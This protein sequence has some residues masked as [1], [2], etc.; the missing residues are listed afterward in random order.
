MMAE[1]NCVYYRNCKEGSL[2]SEISDITEVEEF[3]YVNSMISEKELI[4]LR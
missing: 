2:R 4:T 1:E 3:E